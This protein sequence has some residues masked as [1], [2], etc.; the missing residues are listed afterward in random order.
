LPPNEVIGDAAN[1]EAK[2]APF[3]PLPEM[4][5]VKTTLPLPPLTV[6]LTALAGIPSLP[7]ISAYISKTVAE[8]YWSGVPSSVMRSSPTD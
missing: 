3:R 4:T 5:T 2:A 6:A 7:A 1:V 8:V